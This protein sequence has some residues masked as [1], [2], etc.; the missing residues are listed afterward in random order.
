MKPW[1]FSKTILVQL[2]AA[3]AIV[4]G[5]FVPSVGAFLQVHFAEA[6]IA[7]AIIN[8]L[9]RFITKKEITIS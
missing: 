1:Y 6:G 4:A 5:V 8:G 2:I 3:L 9:L 7:W